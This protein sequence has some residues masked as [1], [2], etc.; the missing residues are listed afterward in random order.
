MFSSQFEYANN[1]SG[2]YASQIGRNKFLWAVK[3]NSPQL[4]F[5]IVK[6]AHFIWKLHMQTLYESMAGT[7]ETLT[8]F[9][10]SK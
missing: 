5:I 7:K 6:P 9:K 8:I 3:I 2:C 1:N 10:S 4:D